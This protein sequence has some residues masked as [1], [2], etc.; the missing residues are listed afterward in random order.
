MQ[1]FNQLPPKEIQP[2]AIAEKLWNEL[3]PS[4]DTDETR[5]YWAQ[6]N[7][8]LLILDEWDK[9]DCDDVAVN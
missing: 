6:I 5:A 9:P 2:Y 4:G 1:I 7:Y 8:H 3:N